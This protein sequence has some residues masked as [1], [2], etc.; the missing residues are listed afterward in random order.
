[1][2]TRPNR[3]PV[4]NGRMFRQLSSFSRRKGNRVVQTTKWLCL[5]MK[6]YKMT[7]RSRVFDRLLEVK[8]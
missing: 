4:C 7:Y 2:R 3:C 1:M 8:G 6:H 5:T